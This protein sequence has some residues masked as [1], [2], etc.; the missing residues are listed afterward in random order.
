VGRGRT[1]G[2]LQEAGAEGRSCVHRW[3]ATH[4]LAASRSASAFSWASGSSEWVF[5]G[6]REIEMEML[7]LT[8]SRRTRDDVSV[9]DWFNGTSCKQFLTIIAI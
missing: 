9:S 6:V 7:R 4:P 8:W 3:G 1:A 2:K 5:A